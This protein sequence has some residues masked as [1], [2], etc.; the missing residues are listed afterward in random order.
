MRV[1]R[2]FDNNNVNNI[3]IPTRFK[4]YCRFVFKWCLFINIIFALGIIFQI[5]I[6]FVFKRV[7]S[8]KNLHIIYKFMNFILSSQLCVW[9]IDR[10]MSQS[11]S[12][13]KVK[14]CKIRTTAVSLVGALFVIFFML[15]RLIYLSYLYHTF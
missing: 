6:V 12:G 9:L 8:A 13:E 5:F 11:V 15:L 3:I 1:K 4:W 2:T 7:Y 14:F 10:F